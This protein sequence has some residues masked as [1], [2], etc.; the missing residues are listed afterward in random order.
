LRGTNAIIVGVP[1]VKDISAKYRIS[2]KRAASLLD[3]F[4]TL[5]NAFV[6]WDGLNLIT[7][8]L[9]QAGD[10]ISLVKYAIYPILLLITLLFSIYTRIFLASADR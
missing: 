4:A 7:V 8:E 6:F 2:Q 1:I 9:V 10:T 3:V 5:T